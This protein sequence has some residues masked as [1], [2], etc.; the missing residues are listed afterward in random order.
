[1]LTPNLSPFTATRPCAPNLSAPKEPGAPSSPAALSPERVGSA[2]HR[3][4]SGRT[5]PNPEAR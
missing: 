5:L 4:R 2:L 1:M 3:M